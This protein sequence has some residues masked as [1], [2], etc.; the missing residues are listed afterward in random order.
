MRNELLKNYYFNTMVIPKD[1][2]FLGKIS[3][4]YIMSNWLF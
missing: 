4:N 3:Y 2:T 1:I